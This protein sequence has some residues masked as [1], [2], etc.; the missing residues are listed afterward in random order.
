MVMTDYTH[1]PDL[2]S[3][4]P[5]FQ[6][7]IDTTAFNINT[8]AITN[9][10]LLPSLTTL[11][12]KPMCSLVGSASSLAT[13]SSNSNSCG[14]SMFGDCVTDGSCACQSGYAGSSCS[15]SSADYLSLTSQISS[16]IDSLNS[17]QPSLSAST[18]L[19]DLA[20][21]TKTPEVITSSSAQTALT[22]LSNVIDES[23]STAEREEA[24]RILSS[25]S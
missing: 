23:S 6:S 14:C 5:G 2:I 12:G 9:T 10:D 21:L 7:A 24:L 20:W 17:N 22:I 16:N 18:V 4:D 8:V 13:P 19:I 25:L 15:Y 3:L 1:H 11:E